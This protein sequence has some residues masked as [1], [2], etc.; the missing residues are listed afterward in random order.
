MKL[1]RLLTFLVDSCIIIW[2]MTMKHEMTALQTKKMLSAELKSKMEKKPFSKITVSEIATDCGVNRKTFYYHFEDI[3]ELLKWTL[4]QEAIEIVKKFDLVL[5]SEEATEF[6]L[7]YV[8]ENKHILNCAYDSIGRDELK[9]FFHNDFTD[10]TMNLIESI[11]K[12]E[13]VRV[14]EEYKQ[15]LCNFYTEAISGMLV[16][17]LRTRKPFDKKKVIRYLTMTLKS[18]LTAA[19]RENL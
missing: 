18:A 1:V 11:E 14:D 6:V 7:N 15:F 3:Q 9:R 8:E 10:I 19:L 12:T 17:I 16:E 4:E 13:N 2:V 5:D